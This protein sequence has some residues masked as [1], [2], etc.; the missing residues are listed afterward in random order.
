[1]V[2]FD[3]DVLAEICRRHDVRE[4]RLFGSAARGEEGPESD[5]DLLVDFGSRKTF[6]ELGALEEELEDLL[7]RPVD[8]LT[9]KALSPLLKDAILSQARV[10]YASGR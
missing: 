1:M 6:I 2:T 9:E 7:G 8:L 3:R 10:L 4:L 5:V